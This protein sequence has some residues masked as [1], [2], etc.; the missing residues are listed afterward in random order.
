MFLVTAALLAAAPGAVAVPRHAPKAVSPA[1][2]EEYRV[3]LEN[4]FGGAIQ[5]SRDRGAT[6]KKVGAV[7]RPNPGQVLETDDKGFTAADWAPQGAVAAT[8]VNAI[9]VKVR[10]GE[11]HAVIFSLQPRDLMLKSAEEVKSYYSSTTSVFTDVPAGTGL[12]GAEYAPR[13]GDPVWVEQPGG[14]VPMPSDY[15]PRPGD[16]L[17]FP[18]FRP[19]RELR[20]LRFRNRV[21]GLVSATYSDGSTESIA[22]V[23]R[24]VGAIGRF[25]GTQFAGLGRVRANHPGVIC[26]STAPPGQ[27][28]GF[29]I[30]PSVHAREPNLA[31]VWS[32]I[33]AWLIVGPLGAAAP[34]LEGQPPMFRG[35]IRPATGRC[36]VRFGGGAWLP[37]PQRVGLLKDGL[38]GVTDI[39]VRFGM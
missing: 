34:P 37:V 36:E 35:T 8:A 24:P 5:L 13:L 1:G 32:G 20:E 38:A 16:V 14:P 28:G 25:G 26:V 27:I 15:V 2:A 30:V 10:Q 29:Q 23:E 17:V 22:Q 12:F 33:N 3:R 11:R 31:Y 9:H 21:G 39:R 4:R 19:A 6:W 18:C 7:L